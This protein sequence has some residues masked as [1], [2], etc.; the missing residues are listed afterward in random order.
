MLEGFEKSVD[1]LLKAYMIVKRK[2]AG[3]KL[4]RVGNGFL[5]KL[6]GS[7]SNMSKK[8]WKRDLH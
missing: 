3:A 5:A 6:V 2:Y 4:V 7:M 1:M 8:I